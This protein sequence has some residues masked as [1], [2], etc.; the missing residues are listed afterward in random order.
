MPRVT[1]TFDT[2][3]AFL[4][5]YPVIVFY[6]FLFDVIPQFQDIFVTVQAPLGCEEIVS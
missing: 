1:V 2:F 6:D 3:Q 5:M 4:P